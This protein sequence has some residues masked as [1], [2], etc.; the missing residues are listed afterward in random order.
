MVAS[1]AEVENPE[2]KLH[3][4]VEEE[5]MHPSPS[6]THSF[7]EQL[8]AKPYFGTGESTVGKVSLE[9]DRICGPSLT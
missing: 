7:I 3:G 6:V 5:K 4:R 8:F 1:L 9:W 2:D